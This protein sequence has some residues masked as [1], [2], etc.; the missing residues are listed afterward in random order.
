M[1]K[2]IPQKRLKS[3]ALCNM[4]AGKA[5]GPSGLTFDLF[6]LCG[7]KGVKRLKDMAN[8]L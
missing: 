7:K 2:G 8:G 1:V 3:I 6:K 5:R 4:K